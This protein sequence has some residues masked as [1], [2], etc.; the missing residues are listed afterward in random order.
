MKKALKI[1]FNIFLCIAHG[2]CILFIQDVLTVTLIWFFHDAGYSQNGG[3]LA[4]V[5]LYLT[6][7]YLALGQLFKYELIC[8][9]TLPT[10]RWIDYMPCVIFSLLWFC[11][12]SFSGSMK[13]PFLWQVLFVIAVNTTI[14]LARKH[15]SSVAIGIS[16][17]QQ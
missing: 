7:H 8:K 4:G 9:Y 5:A 14:I 15:I 17:K 2:L 12:A 11:I 13:P 10:L 3:I 1:M 16:V 6:L